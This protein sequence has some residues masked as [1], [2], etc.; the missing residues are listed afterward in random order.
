MKLDRTFQKDVKEVFKNCE[1]AD[2]KK[3]LREVGKML[4]N[5][6]R[7]DDAMRNYGRGIVAICTAV[8][9]LDNISEF[10][11]AERAW[12]QEVINLL[13]DSERRTARMFGNF[14]LHPAILADNMRFLRRVTTQN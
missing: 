13:D 5:R 7:Y 8:A 14:W 9:V 6:Y 11:S 2:R 10:E 3:K 12:A 4:S 1:L